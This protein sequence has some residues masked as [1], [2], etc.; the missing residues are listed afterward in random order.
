[1]PCHAELPTMKGILGGS[2]GSVQFVGVRR[3]P[4]PGLRG[5]P[6]HP[7]LGLDNGVLNP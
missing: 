3:T 6:V 4:L 1:M 2:D 5:T 7:G